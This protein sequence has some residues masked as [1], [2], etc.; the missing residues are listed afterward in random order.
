MRLHV[1]QHEVFEEPGY[2]L[3]WAKEKQFS[4]SFTRFHMQ[5]TL[6]VHE[7]YDML[8]IMG[9]PM[10]VHDED[11]YP[12]LAVEKA[13]IRE[14]IDHQKKIVGVCLGSQLL[15]HVL[16]AR[17]YRNRWKE[18]GFYDVNH[19]GVKHPLIDGLPKRFTAFHW[20]GDTYDL[21]HECQLLYRSEACENQAY[22]WKNRILGLQFHLEVTPDL[23]E[24]FLDNADAELQENS[25][26]IQS[27][28]EMRAKTHLLTDINRI[29]GKMLDNFLQL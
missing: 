27:A 9:G 1:L 2:I 8:V 6:P 16:G 5:E 19:T 17:V 18:I 14:A 20:H 7:A 28:A 11:K 26:F 21:P 13:F 23:L 29:L 4:V 25:P 12:W 3:H 15:A 10:G 22:V 24:L